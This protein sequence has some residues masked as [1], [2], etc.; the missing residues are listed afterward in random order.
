METLSLHIRL[1]GHIRVSIVVFK[2]RRRIEMSGTCPYSKVA[3]RLFPL[4][5]HLLNNVLLISLIINYRHLLLLLR[6][7]IT[8]LPHFGTLQFNSTRLSQVQL[9]IVGVSIVL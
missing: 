9:P 2:L 4:I 6:G 5:V 8:V 7:T 3:H 1:N